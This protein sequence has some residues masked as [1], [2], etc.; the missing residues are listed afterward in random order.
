MN[1]ECFGFVKDEKDEYTLN[2]ILVVLVAN[3]HQKNLLNFDHDYS[4]YLVQCDEKTEKLFNRKQ[5]S[6]YSLRRVV[7]EQFFDEQEKEQ[8][9]IG[10]RSPFLCLGEATEIIKSIFKEELFDDL[11]ANNCV[12]KNE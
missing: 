6:L 8:I 12:I 2:Y 7:N 1:E 5:L 10:N 9:S 3:W 4:I 11:C